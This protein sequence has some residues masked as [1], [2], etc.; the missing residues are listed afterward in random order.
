M[1]KAETSDNLTEKNCAVTYLPRVIQCIAE[2]HSMKV[3]NPIPTVTLHWKRRDLLDQLSKATNAITPL[4]KAKIPMFC[5]N[6]LCCCFYARMDHADAENMRQYLLL[7]FATDVYDI[8]HGRTSGRFF[9]GPQ[10]IAEIIR[11]HKISSPNQEV[12][13]FIFRMHCEYYCIYN[14]MKSEALITRLAEALKSINSSEWPVN[15]SCNDNEPAVILQDP[16]PPLH[17]Q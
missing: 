9:L 8:A 12:F 3:W 15:T 14:Q 4:L 5:T 13:D 6:P 2:I 11:H 7:R 17:H 16:Q 10:F 1:L